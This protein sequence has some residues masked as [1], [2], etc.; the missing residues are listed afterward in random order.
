VVTCNWNDI[1]SNHNT[2]VCS[3]VV[4]CEESDAVQCCL[5]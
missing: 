2:D 3:C 4:L 1:L 5:P